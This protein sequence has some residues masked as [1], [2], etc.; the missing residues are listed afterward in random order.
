[1]NEPIQLTS[2]FFVQQERKPREQR[3][4]EQG[5]QAW[6]GEKTPSAKY[7]ELTSV[8]LNQGFDRQKSISIS[9]NQGFDRQN[10]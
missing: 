10:Q 4:C 1:L 7:S 3:R 2:R 6:Q 9:L 8:S 5:F